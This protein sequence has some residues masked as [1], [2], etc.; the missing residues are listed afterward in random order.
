[1]QLGRLEDFVARRTA[2]AERYLEELSGL[3][4]AASA[5]AP[6]WPG[7]HAW[8]LFIV[9]LDDRAG[10]MSREE[11]MGALK[12]RGIGTGIHFRAAHEHRYYR[13]RAQT[14]R[15]PLPPRNGTVGELLSLPLFP[16][17]TL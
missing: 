17:M 7:R 9:R 16:D 6:P 1:M 11:L 15:A 10:G 3:D 4:A 13:E 14:L 5:A 12:E 2:L 8:H